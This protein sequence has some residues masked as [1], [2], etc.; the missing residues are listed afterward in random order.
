MK[1]QREAALVKIKIC[2]LTRVED[3]I[4]ACECHA[5]VDR[6]EFLSRAARGSSASIA[7]AKSVRRLAD[8][9]WSPECL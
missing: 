4:A 7:P 6:T 5:D 9:R 3:A 8:R 2:G 1:P